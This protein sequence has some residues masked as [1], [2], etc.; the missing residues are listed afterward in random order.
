MISSYIIGDYILKLHKQGE[1]EF[2]TRTFA[3][4]RDE[5][6]MKKHFICNTLARMESLGFIKRIR[7]EKIATPGK[8]TTVLLV[9]R[10]AVADFNS[11]EDYVGMLKG[12]KEPEKALIEKP[13]IT[14]HIL[15]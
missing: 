5:H 12:N 4:L 7:T 9:Y 6:G 13:W 14:R 1:V 10:L 3:A 8:N 15:K 2:T 11:Y